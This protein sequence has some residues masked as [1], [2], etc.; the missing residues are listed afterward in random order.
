MKLILFILLAI[1]LLS[2]CFIP[3]QHADIDY[4]KESGGVL[5]D[6]PI[7]NGDGT[8]FLP[9][10]FETRIMNSAH[11][12]N[13][14]KMDLKGNNIKIWALVGLPETFG[15]QWSKGINLGK[16]KDGVYQVQYLNSDG[17]TV[18]ISK[19]EIKN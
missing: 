14:V 16:L 17:S 13:D 9:I 6:T 19:I 10:K 11:V 15:H 8:W 3:S 4:F 12:F 7:K 1:G 2:C 5:I 18:E